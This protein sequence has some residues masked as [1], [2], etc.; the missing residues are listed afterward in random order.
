MNVCMHSNQILSQGLLLAALSQTFF[1]PAH[2]YPF[3]AYFTSN[4]LRALFVL[5]EPEKPNEHSV[6]S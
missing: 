5:Y 4:F 3:V 2:F 6:T 1:N